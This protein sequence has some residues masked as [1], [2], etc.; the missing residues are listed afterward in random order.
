MSAMLTAVAKQAMSV[1][2]CFDLVR[3]DSR[4]IR[5]SNPN[6]DLKVKS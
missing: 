1:S 3:E 6:A 4:Q 5:F 2:L